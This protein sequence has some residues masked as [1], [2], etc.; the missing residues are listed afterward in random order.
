MTRQLFVVSAAE[1]D[2]LDAYHWY[3]ARSQGLGDRFLDSLDSAFQV[4]LRNPTAFPRVLK[5]VHRSLTRTF[6][7]LI[8]FTSSEDSVHVLAVVHAAQDPEYIA[9]RLPVDN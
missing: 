4:M 9:S 8:F 1:N 2:I 7:Y 5:D 3:E 6:P